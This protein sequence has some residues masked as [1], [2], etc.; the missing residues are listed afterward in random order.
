MQKILIM[1]L[2]GSGKTT[3]ARALVDKIISSGK[4]VVWLNAD[5]IREN[6]ND[7][8]FSHEGRIRQAHRLRKLADEA[9][10]DFVVCDFIA[11]LSQ[12]RDI[13]S[14]DYTYWLNTISECKYA[15][16]NNMFEPPLSTQ[17]E[18]IIFQQDSNKWSQCIY[19]TIIK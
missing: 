1:G 13:F 5:T 3:L 2:S 14:A 9:T 18:T 12:Q 19:N 17:C 8:D 4:S 7:W 15:D 16:T 6:T 11:A 10:T